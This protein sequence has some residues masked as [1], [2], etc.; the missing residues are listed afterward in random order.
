MHSAGS[1]TPVISLD[2]D[3]YDEACNAFSTLGFSE[4][5]REECFVNIALVLQLGNLRFSP[6]GSGGE[7]GRRREEGEGCELANEKQLRVCAGL[8]QV[9]PSLLETCLCS[10]RVG[11]RGGAVEEMMLPRS[12]ETAAA[13]R[14][15]MCMH[16]YSLVFGWV[17]EEINSL[18]AHP[19]EGARGIG[20]LDIFGFEDIGANSLAQ[21]CINYTNEMLHHL[22]LNHVIKQEQEVRPPLLTLA[23]VLPSHLPIHPHHQSSPPPSCL[24]TLRLL[25]S[26]LPSS[27]LPNC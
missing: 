4:A 2:H 17:V 25:P 5:Q 10:R 22:F 26:F 15:S 27:L 20:L 12:A 23:A 1:A 19:G 13:V 24:P 16:I 7:G 8:L 21:L 11:G 3:R 9:D 6:K 18:L 14:A